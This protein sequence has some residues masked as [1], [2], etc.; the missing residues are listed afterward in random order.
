MKL[1]F[2]VAQ[3]G[4]HQRQIYNCRAS[5]FTSL[6]RHFLLFSDALLCELKC[7]LFHRIATDVGRGGVFF[8]NG[9]KEGPTF[10][11]GPPLL[12]P[13]PLILQH[14]RLTEYLP[15]DIMTYRKAKQR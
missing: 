11:R 10:L 5:V 7:I 9:A 1:V 15:L 14:S 13:Y 2:S 8:V 12:H 4:A 3:L 6:L